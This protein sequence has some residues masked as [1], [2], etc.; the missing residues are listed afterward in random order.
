MK[1]LLL[2]SGVLAAIGCGSAP[3]VRNPPPTP[4]PPLVS[5]LS[6]AKEGDRLAALYFEIDQIGTRPDRAID[7]ARFSLLMGRALDISVDLPARLREVDAMVETI[8]QSGKGDPDL[9][10]QIA[11]IN[12]AMYGTF[13][14]RYGTKESI[15][16]DPDWARH[17]KWIQQ[18]L[19]TREGTAF[20]LTCLYIAV[21]D[22][23]GFRMSAVS[24]PRHI[25]VRSSGGGGWVNV[26]TSDR[27][28]QPLDH[29][30][31]KRYGPSPGGPYY[32]DLSRR[33][34]VGLMLGE[35]GSDL[36]DL[37]RPADALECL[38]RAEALHPDSPEVLNNAGNAY[39][40]LRRTDESL[41]R[42]DQ[43]IQVSPR[44]RTGW[45]N[46]AA[47]LGRLGRYT[48][49]LA[50]IEEALKIDPG[51]ARS[52]A[53]KAGL[54]SGLGRHEE[55]LLWCERAL[56]ID[57]DEQ[58]AVGHKASILGD[59]RRDEEA[60]AVFDRALQLKPRSPILW[61]NRA[62]TYLRLRRVK[63]ALEC[64]DRAIALNPRFMKAYSD[65]AEALARAGR[66]REALELCDRGLGLAPDEPNLLAHRAV[67]LTGLGRHAEALVANER[68]LKIHPKSDVLWQNRG[69]SLMMMK[70]LQ[71][72]VDSFA[73]AVELDPKNANHRALMGAAY[74][75]MKK[76][77][78]ALACAD[79]A[80]ALNPKLGAGW[81]VKLAAHK[82]R[83]EPRE[84]MSALEK[85][86]S[87]GEK[88]SEEAIRELQKMIEDEK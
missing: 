19:A 3:V 84:A 4:A 87:L 78:E 82:L 75:M 13:G 63:E 41:A 7:V 66:G 85:A 56:Q 47:E 58:D 80:I 54:L 55:A 64:F 39:S 15:S 18:V 14:L 46:K 35:L 77:D 34:L 48:E 81:M 10:R 9:H 45:A 68:A 32:R 51:F 62:K 21:A 86:R 17:H 1:Q 25:Y 43:A 59:L 42:Y 33:E 67:F 79:A 50:A 20:G 60:L 71:E 6:E 26:E 49:A 2:L 22:R 76:P 30:Y 31:E 24:A 69:L 83:K 53:T 5:D 8:R 72:S 74:M 23:L 28:R 11:A 38:R 40:R 16:A 52:L 27:G 44:E 29:E 73:R 61:C 37:D 65:K 57:P 88:V 12:A 36:L 70:K